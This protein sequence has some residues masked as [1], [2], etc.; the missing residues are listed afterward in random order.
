VVVVCGSD[1]HRE[2]LDLT[3]EL[4]V[5]FVTATLGGTFEAKI[6]GRNLRMAIPPNSRQGSLI[7]LPAHGLSNGS[8]NQG[9]LKLHLVLAMPLTVAHL[10]NEQRQ[11]FRDMFADA[12]RRRSSSA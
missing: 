1:F 5:D 2:G 3:G 11:L 7:R 4:E 10:T 6:L 12:A 9:D 8:G